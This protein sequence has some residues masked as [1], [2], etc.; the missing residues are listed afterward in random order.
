MVL[1]FSGSGQQDNPNEICF[2][3]KKGVDDGYLLEY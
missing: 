3:R 2:A 1:I